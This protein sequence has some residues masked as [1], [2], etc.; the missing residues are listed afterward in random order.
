MGFIP[1]GQPSKATDARFPR[2]SDDEQATHD[3][4]AE[5][6][7]R[8]ELDQ[9]MPDDSRVALE[10]EYQQRFGKNASIAQ[11]DQ[12]QR[13]FIPLANADAQRPARGF[14]PLTS[15]EP[16]RSLAETIAPA[17]KTAQA[18]GQIYPVAE[19]AAN[20]IT[21]GA[22]M[23]IAGIAGLGAAATK[24]IGLTDADPA[25]VV[26][27]VGGALTYQ[28]ATDLG[29]HLTQ[30]T[31]LPFEKLA[32]A[33]QYAGGKTLDAT[34]SPVAAT[35]VD[36][37]INAL[38]MVIAP[39][40]KGAK[41]ALP[42]PV[43]VAPRIE[44]TASTEAARGFV[45]LEPESV[46][47]SDAKAIE[48]RAQRVAGDDSALLRAELQEL[49]EIRRGGDSG[50]HPLADELSTVPARHGTGAESGVL[51]G[52]VGRERQLRTGEL[53]LDEAAG[54]GAAESVLQ[55]GD[56]LRADTDGGRGGEIARAA[57]Q[58]FGSAQSGERVQ[59][60]R[61]ASGEAL[62]ALDDSGV[63]GRNLD[64]AAVGEH[65]RNIEASP[66]G[67]TESRVADRAGGE[68]LEVPQPKAAR[69]ALIEAENLKASHDT[70]L[71]P[72]EE[73][74]FGRRDTPRHESEA[75]VQDIVR[76]FD[77]ARLA[78][79]MDDATGAPIVARD[80]VV[81]AGQR[82]VIALQRVYQANGAKAE[83]YRQHLR[84]N[85]ERFGIDPSAIDGMKKPVLV[86]VSD[87][88]AP[89]HTAV[90]A[91]GETSSVQSMAEVQN[92]WAPG[93]NYVSLRDSMPAVATES[94]AATK[95]PKPIRREDVLRPF[96]DALG[97]NVYHGRVRGKRLG[98][99]MPTKETLRVKN[100]SDLEVTAH[101]IGH[102][103]DDRIPAI[104]KAWRDDKELREQLK[105]VSYDKKSVSEGYPEAVRIWLSNPRALE[106]AAPKAYGWLETF[107]ETHP[108]GEALRNAQAGMTSWFE[109]SAID[110]ARSKIGDPTNVHNRPF[111]DFLG[112]KWND[113]RKGFRQTVVD[114]LDGVMAAEKN[115]TGKLSPAGAYETARL[116]RAAASITD[117]AIRFGYPVRK[118]DGSFTY[119]GKGLEEILRP[120][121]G[122]LDDF[123]TYAVGRSA[124]E[125]Q[126]QGRENLF[127]KSEVQSM[128]ALETPEFRK[129]FAEYG[130]WNKGV[131]DFA[132]SLGT[133]NPETRKLW[134]RNEYVPFWR[135]DQGV[136][137]RGAVSGQW[138]G[139]KGLK[140]GTGNLRAP[141]ENIIKNANMLIG[142]A[143]KN[144]ARA[145]VVELI[146]TNQGGGRFMQ[147]IPAESKQV[148]VD[149]KQVADAVLKGMGIDSRANLSAEAAL[150]VKHIDAQIAEAP[151]FYSFYVGGQAPN[152]SNIVAVMKG[153]KPE[154]FE[155]AD[156]LLLRALTAIDRPAQSWVIKL[157]GMP[158]RL[159]QASIVLDPSF[160][161][162]N[163]S[164]DQV[165]SGIMTR[166]GYRP[167]LDAMDGMRRRMTTDPLY[168][169]WVANGGGASSVFLDES[170]FRANLER[171]YQR[172]G[173]DYRTVIDS[174]KKFLNLI[175]SFGDAFESATRIGE[176]KRGLAQGDNPRHAAYKSREVSVDFSQSGDSPA[177]KAL[178]DV[179]MFLKPTVVS[180]DRLYRGVAHDPNRGMI[181]AKAAMLGLASAGLYLMNRGDSRYDDMPDYLKDS[182]WHVFLGEK[183]F[184]LPKA[185][186]A[187]AIGSI[188]ERTVE[189]VLEGD[190]EGLGKDFARIIANTFHLNLM[191]QIA[192]PLVE[193]YANKNSFTGSPIETPGHENVQ[194]F[195]RAKPT[196]SET[197]KAVGMATKNLPEALQ[198]NPVRAEAL[199]RGYLNSW[200]AYGLLA[201][202]QFIFGKNLP[203][204]RAD[205]VPVVRRFYQSEPARRTHFENDFYQFLGEAKRLHGTM[206]QLDG[207]GRS[208]IADVK[209]KE[210]L[211]SEAKPLERAAK[212][213][214]GI[215]RDM[216]A[217]RRSEATPAEKRQKLDEL[218]VE[219]NALLKAAVQESKA[220]QGKQ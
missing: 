7:V 200:A 16:S 206:R 29:K 40:A 185:F 33:G 96:L 13:G 55:A 154:Y 192:A 85:A 62:Q 90:D 70:N 104:R 84:E 216:L 38:P 17:V 45:P 28:P 179:V 89:R 191:P 69:Y 174:P 210:P 140:G 73:N 128:T 121:A 153:G 163:F 83:T 53:P 115:L 177:V 155:V 98:Y 26:H 88:A 164:R 30:A 25:D 199:L 105:S 103:L 218:T 87:E 82:R 67:S 157:L 124:R 144:D 186:E 75:A 135:V 14:I 79:S 64:P 132:E 142:A 27:A 57:E 219:R 101:E 80:G 35:A 137:G 15:T 133:L 34:G 117:G 146:E 187:G 1:L 156:P 180:W 52:A 196:T 122:R 172:Q 150:V 170:K 160:M 145:K 208:D 3:V 143:L 9:D 58:E 183:H 214:S 47:G 50:F 220:A 41:R 159:G 130:I 161:A 190:P 102:L 72:V 8:N 211:A 114:D 118:G 193:Q 49:P 2:V 178:Y 195:L 48:P 127:S 68:S 182:H 109:Q 81:E 166:S 139:V 99:Y 212:N 125:L 19:T 169:D 176:F 131:L 56:H 61:P 108:Y 111:L 37:A 136:S 106:I 202:D 149:A 194:P 43:D 91:T 31:M 60:G 204:M 77:P 120:V 12:Q 97:I 51:A 165:L 173:I 44:P 184:M 42:K 112:D 66:S 18:I 92:S 198:L 181:A 65:G 86:R 116:S 95:T 205:E 5:R 94:P 129:A 10:R 171:F 217:V 175:E 24:A 188:A 39:A 203:E 110:R 151:D 126:Q 78:E 59:P 201:S 20:L 215:N 36:T 197:L 76:D 22:A 138:T 148:K 4:D 74:T 32:E 23:P 71:R 167:L 168:R 147:R 123:T 119:S 46:R 21:Q 11:P 134:K 93:Q 63:Q 162:A 209:E 158:K 100:K 213:L 141:L 107:A 152:G 54:A 113:F 6:L 189:K 207:M